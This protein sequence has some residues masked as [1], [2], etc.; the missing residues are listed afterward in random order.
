MNWESV[1]KNITI[2]T[3]APSAENAW[4]LIKNAALAVSQGKIV[5]VG[6]E[7]ELHEHDLSGVSIHDGRGMLCTPGLIDCHTHLVYGGSRANE[8]EMRLTGVSYEEIAKQGGGIVSTVKATREASEQS[9]MRSAQRRLNALIQEG[10][11]TVEIK[12]GYGLDTETELKMLRVIKALGRNNDISIKSTFLGAHAVPAEY[13]T[14]PDAYVELVC[15][16]MLPLVYRDS[17]ADT[18]DVFC[19]GIG[20]SLEQTRKVLDTATSYGMRVKLHAEQLSNLGGSELCAE[21]NGL[22]SDHVEYIDEAGVKALSEANMCAV[23]LPGAFYYLRE[24]QKPPVDL[25]RKHQVS[26]AIASDMNPGSSP[27]CSLLLMMNMACTF[28]NLTP[29]EALAGVTRNAAKALGLN[30]RGTIEEGKRA[31]FVLWDI[32]NPAELSYQFGAIKPDMT[33]I[34]GRFNRRY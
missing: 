16:E 32:D 15:K 24:T 28:F 22:S 3:M 25:L 12:S 10:V 29:E 6:K 7:D 27:V 4:G 11:T 26:V 17:L 20:F 19:E 9:L 31:D 13:K 30:D 5:W 14:D 33:V 34:A 21:Y 8:F 23:L 2:A 1:W 18:V